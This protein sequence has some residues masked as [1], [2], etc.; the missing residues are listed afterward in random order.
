MSGS[1]VSRELR[2]LGSHLPPGPRD[3]ATTPRSQ[4]RVRRPAAQF[5]PESTTQDSAGG[6]EE[7]GRRKKKGEG[8]GRSTVQTTSKE[9]ERLQD[10]VSQR[11]VG[12]SSQRSKQMS[13]DVSGSQESQSSYY[14]DDQGSD[15]EARVRRLQRATV[16]V[17]GG[18]RTEPGVY[19]YGHSATQSGSGLGNPAL[20]Q[21][22]DPLHFTPRQESVSMSVQGSDV[23]VQAAAVE[24]TVDQRHLNP[25][26]E[27]G[28]TQQ[29]QEQHQLDEME[30]LMDGEEQERYNGDVQQVDGDLWE[31][32]VQQE[33]EQGQENA[34]EESQLDVDTEAEHMFLLGKVRPTVPGG[35][36]DYVPGDQVGWTA[37]RRLG[38]WE[39]ALCRFSIMED[40]PFQHEEAFVGA[41]EEILR[42]LDAA[43]T[44]EDLEDSLKWMLVVSQALL[45]SPTRGGRAGRGQVA[46]RF[47]AI[48][49]GR[50]DKVIDMFVTDLKR[51]E[52]R[53]ARTRRTESEE[54]VEARMTAKAVSLIA[55]GQVSRATNRLQSN[56]VAAMSDPEVLEEMKRKF[57]PRSR[58]IPE[59]VCKGVA[60]P[61][62]DD[63]RQLLLA[64]DPASAPGSGGFRPGFLVR[65]GEKMSV[66]G[67]E[68]YRKFFCKYA[69]DQ[70][71]DWFTLVFLTVQG[72]PLCKPTAGIR[73]LGVRNPVA[74]TA[75][76]KIIQYNKSALREF[77][78]PVQ[79]GLSEGG[80][81][82]FVFTMR[83]YMEK[84]KNWEFVKLDL[85]NAFNTASRAATIESFEEEPSLRHLASFF[86]M[87]LA[88]EF[89]LE[90]AGQVWGVAAEG[91]PQGDPL[92]MA[93][94]AVTIQKD[95]VNLNNALGVHGGIARAG[96]DDVLAGGPKGTVIPAIRKF[97]QELY[98]RTRCKLQWEKCEYY[99]EEGDLPE[100]APDGLTMGGVQTEDGFHRGV[101]VYGIPVGSEGYVQEAL[102]RKVDN[103]VA[104]AKRTVKLLSGSRHSAWAAY[105]WSLVNQYDYWASLN[106]PRH[107]EPAARKLDKELWKLLEAVVGSRIPVNYSASLGMYDFRVA[108]GDKDDENN[109]KTVAQVLVRLP[110]KQGGLGVRSQAEMCLPAFYGA[111]ERII[112]RMYCGFGPALEH[113][114]GGEEA[115]GPERDGAGRWSR[116]MASGTTLGEEFSRSWSEMREEEQ[117]RSDFLGVELEGPLV[118]P[119]RSAGEGNVTGK[120]RG[121]LWSHKEAAVAKCLEKAMRCY[122][123]QEARPVIVLPEKDKLSTGWLLALPGPDTT[124]DSAEF[125]QAMETLLFLPCSAVK[126]LVGQKLPGSNGV[127][128]PFGDK[129]AAARMPGDGWRRR[130]DTLKRRM[131]AL[132]G[133]AGVPH[134][135]EVFNLFS[136][137]I[138]QEG[139]SRIESGR[140]RQ[141]LVPDLQIQEPPVLGRGFS[142]RV[143]AELK[144][145]RCCPSRYPNSGRRRGDVRAVDRRASTLA[146]E[147]AK[148]A[149]Q[150]DTE[151]GNTTEGEIGPVAERLRNYDLRGFVYGAFGEASADVHDFVRYV[152]E[153]RCQ[154]Q[155]EMDNRGRAAR[156]T[157]KAVIALL[158]GQVR[159]LLSVEGVRSQARLVLDRVG[160]A[161]QGATEAHRRRCFAD[162]EERRLGMERRAVLACTGAGGSI[163][164]KG[165]FFRP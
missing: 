156:F 98:D 79:L 131:A 137:L 154:R 73:P 3:F 101:T 65:L 55:Q 2:R 54:E 75:H 18:N 82:L 145:I 143:L 6:G 10:E 127:C 11:L 128:D 84:F 76:R 19:I 146:A 140:K 44:Q 47:S 130:H 121:E 42:R 63:L 33:D 162:R 94:F 105:K 165:R 158:T 123:D 9:Q 83:G 118:I 67:I 39:C 93:G 148:H 7:A 77:L 35:R 53:P 74:K 144:T 45:R 133:W 31:E 4:L 58:P 117:L 161:G 28:R 50:W 22:T 81:G 129:I 113:D 1:Q 15:E 104:E 13:S 49:E 122:P 109:K 85:E 12:G 16:K 46:V 32:Q 153:E 120:T 138:P 30:Q 69:G 147:Y 57:P 164:R 99:A 111:V 91:Q 5:S 100:D 139:L 102:D 114:Y 151:F 108:L 103:I 25:A 8:R 159:R 110:V 38:A 70:L 56:G 134:E 152:A 68:N 64:A 135:M 97:E 43:E 17:T 61:D 119:A 36:V 95:L 48:T 80:A 34:A 115:F 142:K 149:A 62:F 155:K 66:S 60:V 157:D 87:V 96:A 59:K 23:T 71:P 150:V 88:P 163:V 125:S 132:L 86:A 26:T 27:G 37:I 126:H 20:S 141:G 124:L 21:P 41:Y 51:L 116:L 78:E 160:G 92:S 112:P 40:I 52:D 89:R 29:Q 24:V 107:S 14:R 106:Y 136:H 90:S 72:V